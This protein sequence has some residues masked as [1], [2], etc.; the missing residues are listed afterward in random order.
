MPG[1]PWIRPHDPMVLMM[2]SVPASAHEVTQ[3]IAQSVKAQS[4]DRYMRGSD[5]L[6]S[7]LSSGMGMGWPGT[8]G[9]KGGGC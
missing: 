4:R 5:Q 2:S 6:T 9:T 3:R 8:G 7:K 1:G